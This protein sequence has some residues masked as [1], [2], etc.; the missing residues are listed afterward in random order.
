MCEYDGTNI[1]PIKGPP[2]R[3]ESLIA[4]PLKS[5]TSDDWTYA[6]LRTDDSPTDRLQVMSLLREAYPEL[7]SQLRFVLE[8]WEAGYGPGGSKLLGQG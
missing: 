1:G 5:W 4:R 7:G 8:V 6:V 2:S 3:W